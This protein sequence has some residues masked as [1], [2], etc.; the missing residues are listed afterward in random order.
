MYEEMETFKYVPIEQQQQIQTRKKRSRD[1][2]CYLAAYTL[3]DHSEYM[4]TE[5]SDCYCKYNVIKW[6]HLS[7]WEDDENPK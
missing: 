1:N 7:K 3:S 4:L 6:R 2:I 5:L